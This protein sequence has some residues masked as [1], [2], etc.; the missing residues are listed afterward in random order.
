MK[1]TMILLLIALLMFSSAQASANTMTFDGGPPSAAPPYTEDGMTLTKISSWGW[2][3]ILFSDP[4]GGYGAHMDGGVI[5]FDMGGSFFD[6]DE[7]F[8]DYV[9]DPCELNT[10]EFSNGYTYS[11][12]G[13]WATDLSLDFT[14]DSNAKYVSWF[15]ITYPGEIY[16]SQLDYVS[17][18]PRATIPVPGALLLAGIGAG[19][20]GWMRRRKRL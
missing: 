6:L 15:T 5:K 3:P 11:F 13:D 16:C 2:G 9:H 7:L 14:G 12:L 17:F 4:D 10:I 1:Q 20:V 8:Y 18:T 19:A